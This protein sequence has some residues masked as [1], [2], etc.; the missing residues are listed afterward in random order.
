MSDR[1]NLDV[2]GIDVAMEIVFGG[3]QSDACVVVG[4]HVGIAIASRILRETSVLNGAAD[5]SEW[6]G[7]E[8]VV[9]SVAGQFG[10]KIRQLDEHVKTH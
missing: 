3:N 9:D 2:R 4:N 10:F 8:F 1:T 6:N 5:A 7:V